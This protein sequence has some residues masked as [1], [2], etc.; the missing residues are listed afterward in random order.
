MRRISPSRNREGGIRPLAKNRLKTA[1]L[2]KPGTESGTVDFD[3]QE[4]I[5]VWSR[6]DGVT[7][8]KI[9]AVVKAMVV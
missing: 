3:L 9:L 6:S 8:K 4:L 7:R 5:K 1:K 2:K